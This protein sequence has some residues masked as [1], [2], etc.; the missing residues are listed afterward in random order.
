MC[1]L[2][3]FKEMVKEKKM[4][5]YTMFYNLSSLHFFIQTSFSM[6]TTLRGLDFF[7]Y[8]FVYKTPRKKPERLKAR[9]SSLAF[10]PQCAFIICFLPLSPILMFRSEDRD[11][12]NPEFLAFISAMT[13]IFSIS[14]KRGSFQGIN[15]NPLS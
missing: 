9:I 6:C 7:H 4:H 5:K 8:M 15:L 2:K 13:L 3:S 14:S 10:N 11:K 12:Y 1:N